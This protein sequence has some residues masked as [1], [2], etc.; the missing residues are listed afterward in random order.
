MRCFFIYIRILIFR[1]SFLKTVLVDS[2]MVVCLL[3]YSTRKSFRGAMIN[4]INPGLYENLLTLRGAIWPPSNISPT[5][6]D[7]VMPF[8]MLLAH[9]K[10]FL[11]MYH[12]PH[13]SRDKNA[14][15]SSFPVMSAKNPEI[16]RSG[17][18]NPS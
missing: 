1:F 5:K 9:H 6:R 11:K 8:G 3:E 17:H 15:V 7:W 14:D 13:G 4:P 12:L 16:H 10:T 2:T 18:D